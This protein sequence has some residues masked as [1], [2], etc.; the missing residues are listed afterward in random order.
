MHIQLLARLKEQNGHL[1][2]VEVNKMLCLMCNITS[3][4]SS[5]NAVPCGVVLLRLYLFDISSNVLFNIIFLHCLHGTVHCILLHFVGHV[6]VLYDSFL[7]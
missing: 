2:E 6:C 5:N 3:K 7:L 1:P 4:V